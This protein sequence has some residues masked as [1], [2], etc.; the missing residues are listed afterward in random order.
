MNNSK[1]SQPKLLDRVR[2]ICRLKHY[3]YSTEKTYV[4][5]KGFRRWIRRFIRYHHTRHP[6]H[7][8]ATHVKAFLSYLAVKRK[9][10]ASTQNQAMNA[11]VFLYR[12]VLDVD[13]GDFSGA[14][15]AKRPK[16]LPVVLTRTERGSATRTRHASAGRKSPLPSRSQNG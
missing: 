12:D 15:R 9:V 13:L 14:I 11:L 16:R 7:M 10:S 4:T 8:N 6:L 5:P 3:S 1:S 2:H